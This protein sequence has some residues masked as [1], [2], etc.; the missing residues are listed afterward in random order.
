M[1]SLVHLCSVLTPAKVKQESRLIFHAYFQSYT[2]KI[3][4]EVIF[5]FLSFYSKSKTQLSLFCAVIT[6]Y[7]RLCNLYG[8]EIS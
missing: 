4:C 1:K 5:F 6:E 7:P 3:K 2:H 8:I